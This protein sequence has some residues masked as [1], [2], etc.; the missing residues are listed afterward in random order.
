MV[1]RWLRTIRGVDVAAAR[2]RCQCVVFTT[3]TVYLLKISIF[4]RTK[5]KLPLPWWCEIVKCLL[6]NAQ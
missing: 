1:L 5:T 2:Q 6:F 3:L 4:K